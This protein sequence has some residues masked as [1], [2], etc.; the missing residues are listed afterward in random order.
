MRNDID[1][2][3]AELN[4][5]DIVEQRCP[6]NDDGCEADEL[7]DIVNQPDNGYFMVCKIDFFAKTFLYIEIY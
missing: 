2:A 7:I 6:S 3:N 4:P 5:V 1:E